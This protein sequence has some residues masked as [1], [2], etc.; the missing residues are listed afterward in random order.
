MCEADK[1]R[2]EAKELAHRQA[3]LAER[4]PPRRKKA[5]STGAEGEK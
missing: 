4:F 2:R 5:R 1:E 3:E